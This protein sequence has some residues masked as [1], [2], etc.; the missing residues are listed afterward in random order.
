[1]NGDSQKDI[2]CVPLSELAISRALRQDLR[3]ARV[4]NLA[5]AFGLDDHSIVTYL[6]DRS[7]QELIGYQELFQ[8]DPDALREQLQRKSS[9]LSGYSSQQPR[10]PMNRPGLPSNQKTSSPIRVSYANAERS[11]QRAYEAGGEGLKTSVCRGYGSVRQ[12]LYRNRGDAYSTSM[13]LLPNQPFSSV[14]EKF[15]DE[16]KRELRKLSDHAFEAIVAEA[17]PAFDLLM[18]EYRKS[19]QD[20]FRFYAERAATNKALDIVEH[21][22]R[23]SFVIVVADAARRLHEGRTVLE[24][25]YEEFAIGSQNDQG[26]FKTLFVTIVKQYG[27]QTYSADETAYYYQHTILLH[28]G[29]SGEAWRSLWENTLI[30]LAKSGDMRQ[31]YDGIGILR[32][33]LERDGP[34]QVEN[35][36]VRHMLAKAPPASIAPLLESSLRAAQQYERFDKSS[37][38]VALISSGGLSNEAMQAYLQVIQKRE[39]SKTPRHGAATGGLPGAG[40]KQTRAF[41]W[42]ND[43]TLLLDLRR[44]HKPVCV[45]IQGQR[46]SSDFANRYFEFYVNGDLVAKEPVKQSMYGCI[47]EGT[48]I[49]VAPAEQ[50][51]VETKIMEEAAHGKR[52]EIASRIKYFV[53]AREGVFEFAGTPGEEVLSYRE[54]SRRREGVVR[55]AYLVY[56]GYSIEQGR[57]ASPV[58]VVDLDGDFSVNAYDFNPGSTATV[59]A[60]D[61][62][63]AVW[64]QERYAASI[65]RSWVIG[66]F[67]GRDL[68][69]LSRNTAGIGCNAYLPI[70][71]VVAPESRDARDELDITCTCD[72]GIFH[73]YVRTVGIHGFE[74]GVYGD[75]GSRVII[76]LALT[77]I[78][79]VVEDGHVMVRHRG[80]GETVLDYR[81]A[82]LP[83]KGIRLDA[84]GW[85]GKSY[86]ARYS[87]VCCS[88]MKLYDAVE[89]GIVQKDIDERAVFSAPLSDEGKDVELILDANGEEKTITPRLMLAGMSIELPACWEN[90]SRSISLDDVVQEEG[91]VRIVVRGNRTWESVSRGFFLKCGRPISYIPDAT[92][93][94]R[95]ET[96][97]FLSLLE[98]SRFD[99]SL[100][101]PAETCTLTLLVSYGWSEKPGEPP[102]PCAVSLGLLRKTFDNN[103]HM[104]TS[105]DGI[106]YLDFGQK[107]RCDLYYRFSNADEGTVIDEDNPIIE[108]PTRA[109]RVRRRARIEL[110][111][112]AC[113]PFDFCPDWKL[114]QIVEI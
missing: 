45:R 19:Y 57:T 67:H 94:L 81:F 82:I 5:E 102:E 18:D 104:K 27:M 89:H 76:D 51:V 113:G 39:G 8:K 75:E 96:D 38:D 61:G 12:T 59:I 110:Q 21:K 85:G 114:V 73:P 53:D 9:T 17:F 10:A 26:R 105:A 47:I 16:A 43:P 40:G 55:K 64:L 65:E 1:M 86:Q 78:P 29:L 97:V 13:Y 109:R 93:S 32:R 71:E 24:H 90:P 30:P 42:V 101:R 87:F 74:D 62:R 91:I 99:T 88:S 50:F 48:S 63:R 54:G 15:E 77:L 37:T 58:P 60:P 7:E 34:Y 22:L 111:L 100:D 92:S 70:I 79:S 66:S 3:K 14:L 103:L 72:G 84:I 69:G 25:I 2:L 11:P 83:I 52:R 44:N 46:L 98:G 28:A 106:P 56:P 107:P 31:A 49:W 80:T 112:S 20:F 4:H 33:V 68:Y 35:K 36:G 6:S 108:L 23:N 41:Y 95:H